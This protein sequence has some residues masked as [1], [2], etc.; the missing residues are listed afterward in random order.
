MI[1][2][3][4]LTTNEYPDILTNKCFEV[5]IVNDELHFD[6]KLRDGICK[7]LRPL[8]KKDGSYLREE[9]EKR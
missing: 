1:S 5:E 8:M 7:V 4:A 6:Y 2:K 9:G 3:F